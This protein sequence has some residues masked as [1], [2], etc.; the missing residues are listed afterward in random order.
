M[1]TSDQVGNEFG[2]LFTFGRDLV[3]FYRGNIGIRIE[4]RELTA[5][6][7]HPRVAARNR[8][9]NGIL[10]KPLLMKNVFK[11]VLLMKFEGGL[12]TIK[13]NPKHIE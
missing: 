11:G 9:K 1:V 2:G 6:S 3:E 12:K 4:V 10:K 13:A 5:R 7:K 8:I